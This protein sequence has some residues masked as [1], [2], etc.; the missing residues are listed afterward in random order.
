MEIEK[1][2]KE[3]AQVPKHHGCF[4]FSADRKNPVV[5]KPDMRLRRLYGKGQNLI[6]IYT[7]ADTDRIYVSTFSVAPGRIL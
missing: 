3:K 5:L 6:T 4:P 2:I 1:N 7:C